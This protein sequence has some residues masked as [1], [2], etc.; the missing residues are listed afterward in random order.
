MLNSLVNIFCGHIAQ[1]YSLFTRDR[2][3]L[4]EVETSWAD[5][6]LM[7][8]AD[9]IF[10][11][12]I[13]FLDLTDAARWQVVCRHSY[14][15]IATAYLFSHPSHVSLF[16]R[17][18]VLHA[19]K[20]PLVWQTAFSLAARQL[21]KLD[22][23]ALPWKAIT[24]TLLASCRNLEELNLCCR[25]VSYADL[26][27][28]PFASSLKAISLYWDENYR[29]V[30]PEQ[31]F[32]F[33]GFPR[34]QI[35]SFSL[36]HN[37]HL[38]N[39]NFASL[40]KLEYLRIQAS[41]IDGPL[42]APPCLRTLQ[43]DTSNPIDSEDLSDWELSQFTALER[44]ELSSVVIQQVSMQKLLQLCSL[45]P[46]LQLKLQLILPLE[47]LDQHAPYVLAERCNELFARSA[48]NHDSY[49]LLVDYPAD[50]YPV[51]N[52]RLGRWQIFFDALCKEFK[53]RVTKLHVNVALYPPI[54]RFARQLP[55][56]TFAYEKQ[57]YLFSALQLIQLK[58]KSLTSA[59]LSVGTDL[60]K[61]YEYFKPLSHLALYETRVNVG[62]IACLIDCPN[63]TQFS[64]YNCLLEQLEAVQLSLE[65]THITIFV[66]QQ[67]NVEGLALTEEEARLYQPQFSIEGFK[68]LLRYVSPQL[69][70]V[71]FTRC[72]K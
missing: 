64:L 57:S 39:C 52:S 22:L 19:T 42:R 24:S 5:S 70:E 11:K 62:F 65:Y 10:W 26:C 1:D 72:Q 32:P 71:R 30:E 29:Q 14:R 17:R 4:T 36:Y 58:H 45:A 27:T 59:T 3:A 34:G 2:I 61:Y 18:A 63:L 40:P 31:S 69:C 54:W 9:E 13:T 47:E 60:G 35:C 49:A 16:F 55:L 46:Q 41:S 20:L 48:N 12:I 53:K 23:S 51:E 33:E 21:K 68:R 67:G 44:L 15:K 66:V 38:P 43:I 25:N 50:N 6:P 56:T 7:L 8:L 28:I 37:G